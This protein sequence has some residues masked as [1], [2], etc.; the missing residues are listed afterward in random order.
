MRRR[1]PYH[2]HFCGL[3]DGYDDE[4]DEEYIGLG[5]SP[6]QAQRQQS[7][8]QYQPHWSRLSQILVHQAFHLARVRRTTERLWSS[9]LNNK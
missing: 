3:K 7:I 4:S 8:Q 6:F 5:A 9:F 2:G 1:K